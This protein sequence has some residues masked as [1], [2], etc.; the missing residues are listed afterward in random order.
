MTVTG[1]L[2]AAD[3]VTV[4]VA[5]RVPVLPSVTVASPM[6]M[7][8]S[9]S[10]MVPTPWPSAMVAF[11]G[12]LR[13]TRKVSFGSPSRSPLTRTVMVLLVSPGAKVS[14]PGR[15]LVVAAGRGGAVGG[16][17][18][19]RHRLVGRGGERDR[20][21][22]RLSSRVAFR[23]RDVADGERWKAVL[24][25]LPQLLAM[26][27]VVGREEQRAV[28]VRERAGGRGSRRARCRPRCRRSSTAPSPCV[29][30]LAVKNSVPLTFVR[31]AG[32]RAGDAG[33]DVL[34]QRRCR[35]RCRRS[36]TARARAC[37]R[38]P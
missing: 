31:L 7:R 16:R 13:L 19:D 32:V 4:K 15:G 8:G 33:V 38:R 24:D 36:S 20:K 37:R 6:L 30:S 22:R 18:V 26:D 29:P 12:V 10:T 21:R 27:A 14:V 5:A 11:V 25:Q 3:R 28:D 2:E 23:D 1:S 17:V 9:S 35:R 34:D